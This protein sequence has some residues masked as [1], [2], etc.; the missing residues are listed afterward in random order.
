MIEPTN[1]KL[2]IRDVGPATDG[3]PV[4]AGAG[5]LVDFRP[6]YAPGDVHAHHTVGHVEGEAQVN[7]FFFTHRLLIDHVDQI[8]AVEA[9]DDA[10]FA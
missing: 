4:F 7:A 2:L 1:A 5:D 3:E 10:N 8:N 6:H 9:I